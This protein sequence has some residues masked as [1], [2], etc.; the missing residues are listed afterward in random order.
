MD[1][2]KF[3]CRICESDEYEEIRNNNGVFGPAGRS[4]V[5]YYI[6]KGCSVIFKDN[7]KFTNK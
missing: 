6:C 2:L 5:E 3:K 7:K 1:K 4:W